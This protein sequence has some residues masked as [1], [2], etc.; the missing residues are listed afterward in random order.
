[1]VFPLFSIHTVAPKVYLKKTCYF[2]GQLSTA[3]SKTSYYKDI[4]TLTEL[5]KSGLHVASSSVDIFGVNVSA[6][7]DNLSKKFV[8]SSNISTQLAARDRNITVVQRRNDA[9]LVLEHYYTNRFGEDELHLVDECPRSY[10]LSYIVY[11]GYPFLKQINQ[12]IERVFGAGL[13]TQWYHWTEF[14]IL[15]KDRIN[16]MDGEKD[17]KLTFLDVQGS[18]LFLVIGVVLSTCVFACEVIKF[19]LKNKNKLKI[20]KN[21][22]AFACALYE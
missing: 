11:K 8:K 19:N 17:K 5:D 3:Y 2:Q 10:H 4:N 7:G 6:V 13:S 14:S 1:M 9:K 12:F 18:F 22:K 21:S 15:L 20:K 16:R